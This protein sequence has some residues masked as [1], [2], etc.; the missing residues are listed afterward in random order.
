MDSVCEVRRVV[1][2]FDGV[3]FVVCFVGDYFWYCVGGGD[4]VVYLWYVF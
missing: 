4:Y 1:E 3:F 2:G